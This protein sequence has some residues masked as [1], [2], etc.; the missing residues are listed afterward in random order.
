MPQKCTTHY[1]EMS[2]EVKSI[3]K[4]Y[5]LFIIAA[6]FMFVVGGRCH[7]VGMLELKEE[8]TIFLVA[9]DIGHV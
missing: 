1:E 3:W 5:Y 7:C 9:M 4:W 2:M 8:K 6:T